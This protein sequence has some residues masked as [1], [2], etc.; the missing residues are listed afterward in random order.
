MGGIGAQWLG[1]GLMG[2]IGS[3]VVEKGLIETGNI[4]LCHVMGCL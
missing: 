1:M 4:V 2:R 3:R